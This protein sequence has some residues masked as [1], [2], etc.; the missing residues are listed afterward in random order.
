VTSGFPLASENGQNFGFPGGGGLLPVAVPYANQGAPSG[1]PNCRYEYQV[2]PVNGSYECVENVNTTVWLGT[3]DVQLMPTLPGNPK[4][5]LK[6]HQYLNPTA[7]GIPLPGSNGVY[8]MPYIHGPYYMDHDV[9]VLK[10][11]ALREGQNLQ[12]RMAAFNFLN[13]PLV[14]FNQQDTDNLTLNFNSATAGQA[15]TTNVL[16]YPNFGVANIK[17]GNRL[18]ELEAKYTF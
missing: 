9:T 1:T 8:R 16:V 10:N 14:S 12:V 15:L 3:P 13:H 18:V 2:T 4:S 6:T 11:F 17:V 7:F 5:G